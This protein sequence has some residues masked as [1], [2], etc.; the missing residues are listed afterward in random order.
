M[1]RGDVCCLRLRGNP[2][3]RLLLFCEESDARTYPTPK[4]TRSSGGRGPA[5]VLCRTPQGR[6]IPSVTFSVT[7][8]DMDVGPV[9]VM[10]AGRCGAERRERAL[11]AER[12]SHFSFMVFF[13][14]ATRR[15]VCRNKMREACSRKEE[16]SDVF[17]RGVHARGSIALF[18]VALLWCSSLSSCGALVDLVLPAPISWTS[19]RKLLNSTLVAT[20]RQRRSMRRQLDRAMRACDGFKRE[21]GWSS[22]EL[23]TRNHGT[24]TR[25]RSPGNCP[26]LRRNRTNHRHNAPKKGHRPDIVESIVFG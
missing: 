19:V 18:S 11:L 1:T 17:R 5:A 25:W 24:T 20:R 9:A 7:G 4:A 23:H 14:K 2:P 15:F 22:R 12:T 13:V 3:L 26:S 16:E 10:S 8:A 21:E 6:C